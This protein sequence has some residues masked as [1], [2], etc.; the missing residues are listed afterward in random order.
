MLTQL[1]WSTA[2]TME[3]R[4]T[5]QQ[6]SLA[7]AFKTKLSPDC[8]SKPVSLKAPFITIAAIAA[9][10]LPKSPKWPNG[11]VRVGMA[12]SDKNIWKF[13]PVSQLCAHCGH[14]LGEG[15]VPVCCQ[16][17]SQPVIGTMY[18]LQQN[19]LGFSNFAHEMLHTFPGCK[20][21]SATARVVTCW[22]WQGAFLLS[23][24]FLVN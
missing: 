16:P 2:R 19:G 1:D 12:Q 8:Q 10:F 20:L 11:L 13:L 24:C 4:G 18:D 5:L 17:C 23:S 22:L 7:S 15:G 21:W 6:P 9:H 14:D 3:P